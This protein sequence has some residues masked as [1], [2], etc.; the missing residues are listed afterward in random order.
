MRPEWR[1]SAQPGDYRSLLGGGPVPML[2]LSTTRIFRFVRLPTGPV[3]HFL[4]T[5]EPHS[6]SMILRSLM[7]LSVQGC[8]PCGSSG[9]PQIVYFLNRWDSSPV[10]YALMCVWSRHRHRHRHHRHRLYE[11]F[12]V[13]T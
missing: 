5:V 9:P 10:G 1:G 11:R 13:F 2:M 6:T 4:A 8:W 3:L 7:P 12:R